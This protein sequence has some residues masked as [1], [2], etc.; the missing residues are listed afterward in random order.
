MR[1]TYRCYRRHPHPNPHPNPNRNPNPNPNRNPNPNQ[2]LSTERV[3]EIVEGYLK[4]GESANTAARY[5]IALASLEWKR[6][7][8][9]QYRDDITATVVFLKDLLPV[10]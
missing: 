3:V 1:K 2:F 6:E 8:G 7:E 10:L 4:R 9:G 5:L